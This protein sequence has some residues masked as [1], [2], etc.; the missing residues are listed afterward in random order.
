MPR[1]RDTAIFNFLEKKGSE[2][3]ENSDIQIL[4]GIIK[5]GLGYQILLVQ[6]FF[7][8][9]GFF[10]RLHCHFEIVGF[11]NLGKT[12]YGVKAEQQVGNELIDK[13]ENVLGMQWYCSS[14]ELEC[15]VPGLN[16]LE[17]SLT[18]LV[19]K[20]LLQKRGI[21]HGQPPFDSFVGGPG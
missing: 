14:D 12:E 7:K 2:V 20:L 4:L 16:C 9:I 11:R 6:R 18:T 10:G 1:V 21:P 19:P 15:V 8:Y 17:S 13:V 3:G 5:Y